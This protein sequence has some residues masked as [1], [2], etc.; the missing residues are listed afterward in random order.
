MKK[1][2]LSAVMMLALVAGSAFA[3]PQNK[4]MKTK[5]A[6]SASGGKMGGKKH[7]RKHHR[8]AHRR[9]AKKSANKNM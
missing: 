9:G 4:N 2:I 7:H 3:A 1:V 5:P 6:A 8:R